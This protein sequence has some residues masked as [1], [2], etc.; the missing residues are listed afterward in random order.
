MEKV[1]GEDVVVEVAETAVTIAIKAA[2]TITTEEARGK[3]SC[4][5]NYFHNQYICVFFGLHIQ[6]TFLFF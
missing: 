3:V 4:A 2:V 1:E 6:V 5:V